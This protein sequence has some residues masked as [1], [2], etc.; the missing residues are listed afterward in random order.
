MKIII[1]GAR[2]ERQVLKYERDFT[3]FSEAPGRAPVLSVRA[4]KR[5]ILRDPLQAAMA[6]TFRNLDIGLLDGQ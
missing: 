3:L 4:K 1:S 5:H 6:S 2:A